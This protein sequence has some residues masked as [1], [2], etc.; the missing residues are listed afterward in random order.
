MKFEIRKDRKTLAE[1]KDLEEAQLELTKLNDPYKKS[2]NAKLAYLK[3]IYDE[4]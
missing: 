2:P 1:Y 4:K 3:G